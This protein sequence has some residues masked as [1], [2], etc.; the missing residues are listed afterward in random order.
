V[1]FT[2]TFWFVASAIVV[3]VFIAGCIALAFVLMIKGEG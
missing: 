3:L 2:E 1:K